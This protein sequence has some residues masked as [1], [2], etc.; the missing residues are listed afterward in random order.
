MQFIQFGL[1]FFWSQCLGTCSLFWPPTLIPTSTLSCTCF[2]LISSGLTSNSSSPCYHSLLQISK[3]IVGSSTMWVI[4]QGYLFLSF[5]NIWLI[6][7]CYLLHYP[8]SMKSCCVFF[9]VLVFLKSF[10]FNP[11]CKI[12]L[13]YIFLFWGWLLF[14]E[15][16]NSS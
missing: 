14:S 1:I 3:L 5:L 9:L 2:S 7:I 10:F 8:D 4:W 11:W 6:N 16:P 13:S 12:R 15:T